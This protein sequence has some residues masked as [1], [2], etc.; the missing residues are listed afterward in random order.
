MEDET[1]CRR[2]LEGLHVYDNAENKAVYRLL[3]QNECCKR[4]YLRG[5]FLCAGSMSDPEKFYHFEIVCDTIDK[6]AQLKEIFGSFSVDAGIT[7]RK[8]RF[9]VYVKEANDIVDLLN[10]MG[11]HIS[12]M[13][14]ENVRILKDMRNRVNRRVN[15]ETANLTK[16]VDAAVRQTADIKLLAETGVLSGLSPSLREA[17][18]LRLENPEASLKELG[19]MCDPPVSRAGMNHRLARLSKI[20]EEHGAVRE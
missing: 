12:L 20:A 9:V 4:A 19:A 5:A 13:N 16:T 1:D 18:A 7:E 8:N 2:F 11:A 15:C 3:I 10:L 14:M 6:A 17:A